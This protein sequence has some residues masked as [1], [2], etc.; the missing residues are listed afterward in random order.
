MSPHGC[1]ITRP[2]P[3]PLS[4]LDQDFDTCKRHLVERGEVFLEISLRSRERITAVA[5]PF[6]RDG[7]VVLVHGYSRVVLAILLH[8][9]KSKNFSVVVTEGRPA[10]GSGYVAPPC[11]SPRCDT[12]EG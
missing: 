2:A 10:N 3:L 9:A 7:A 4:P 5:E 11:P 12:R 8:A 1:V 6:I